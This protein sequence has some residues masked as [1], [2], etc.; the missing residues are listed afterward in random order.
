MIMNK[1]KA[2]KLLKQQFKKIMFSNIQ[3]YFTI[4]HHKIIKLHKK[5]K[6]STYTIIKNS[7]G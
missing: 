3:Q 2:S 5:I 7:N 6:M 1:K 4:L